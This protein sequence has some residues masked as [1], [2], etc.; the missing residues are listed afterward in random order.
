MHSKPSG[1]PR[2]PT[3]SWAGLGFSASMPENV[4]KEKLATADNASKERQ[5]FNRHN[6]GILPEASEVTDDVGLNKNKA[7]SAVNT[8][9]DDMFK[10]HNLFY[11]A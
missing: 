2:S 11:Y 3:T 7:P 10:V 5:D 6:L 8:N 4:I 9:L 1:E